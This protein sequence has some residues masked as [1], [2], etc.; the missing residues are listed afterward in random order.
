M[1]GKDDLACILGKDVHHC[2]LGKNAHQCISGKDKSSFNMDRT[3]PKVE[4]R[5]KL[6]N[7]VLPEAG[8]QHNSESF[9]PP[10]NCKEM[11]IR[12]TK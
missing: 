11:L 4:G 1:S 12:E 3:S 2:V 10:P 7:K 5:R 6:G 9:F 8:P